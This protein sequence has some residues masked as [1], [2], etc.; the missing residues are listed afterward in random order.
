[1]ETMS[2]RRIHAADGVWEEEIG[3]VSRRKLTKASAAV[4]SVLTVIREPGKLRH[5]PGQSID[6]DRDLASAI[7]EHLIAEGLLS[8]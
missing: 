5:M 3:V 2:I 4:D 6:D 7:V 8:Q 1:M